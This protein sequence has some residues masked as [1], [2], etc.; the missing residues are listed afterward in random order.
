MFRKINSKEKIVGWYSS[1]PSIRKKDIEINEKYRNY[2]SNPVFV[3]AKVQ[4][5]DQLTIPIEAYSSIEEVN[6]EGQ[7]V[8]NFIHIPSSIEATEAE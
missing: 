1:G 3:V 8:K 4:E 6:E 5:S 2:N 7:L